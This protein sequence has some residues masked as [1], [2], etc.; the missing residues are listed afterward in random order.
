MEENKKI[1][2][3]YKEKLDL[4]KKHN[5]HYYSEDKPR[6][7]DAEYDNFKR[8]FSLRKKYNFYKN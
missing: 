8:N 5:K 2:K 4:L 3:T 7:T 1:I 6:I